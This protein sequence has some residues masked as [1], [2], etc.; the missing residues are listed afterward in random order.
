M[1]SSGRFFRCC[2]NNNSNF[3]WVVKSLGFL[4]SQWTFNLLIFVFI[5]LFLLSVIGIFK[6]FKK[7]IS[8]LKTSLEDIQ[9]REDVA[10]YTNQEKTSSF[11]KLPPNQILGRW[12]NKALRDSKEWASDSAFETITLYTDVGK[13]KTNCYFQMRAISGWKNASKYFYVGK[14]YDI[15]EEELHA[16][17]GQ[18]IEQIVPFFRR[19]RE[20]QTVLKKAFEAIEGNL[21]DEYSIHIASHYTN[22]NM[23]FAYKRGKKK[24]VEEFEFENETLTNLKT[25]MKIQ[26]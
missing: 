9:V 23:Q 6:W 5:G 8:Q 11:P 17:E 1:G 18:S 7:S 20:W 19:Y 4:R 2:I 14:S 22:L 15:D 16:F 10:K 25:K 21:P 26:I 24:Y 12:F 3:I 13:E